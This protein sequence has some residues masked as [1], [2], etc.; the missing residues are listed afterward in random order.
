MGE[1]SG[2]FEGCGPQAG[3]LSLREK[4]ALNFSETDPLVLGGTSGPNGNNASFGD[5]PPNLRRVICHTP[6]YQG[7]P[8][9][10]ADSCPLGWNLS[11]VWGRVG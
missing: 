5:M 11:G 4:D 2:I 1:P 3:S 7:L 6:C 10:W 8:L 9:G